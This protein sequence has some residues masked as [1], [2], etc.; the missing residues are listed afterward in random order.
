MNQVDTTFWP[1]SLAHLTLPYVDASSQY[2]T[3]AEISSELANGYPGTRLLYTAMV[4]KDE[5]PECL[6]RTAGM[7][8]GVS[9]GSEE[10]EFAGT[11]PSPT[12]AFWVESRRADGKRYQSLV[13]TWRVHDRHIIQP[14]GGLLRHFS[15][16]PRV[17]QD[18]KVFW[19]DLSIPTYDVVR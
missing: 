9:S 8:H 18:G 10:I 17:L 4:P 7:G 3:I 13:E 11:P 15:L 19:D 6:E 12:T 16:T 14:W 1:A 2:V 5:V